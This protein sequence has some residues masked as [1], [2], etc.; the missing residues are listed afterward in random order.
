IDEL[1]RGHA[2]GCCMTSDVIEQ[3]GERDRVLSAGPKH[4]ARERNGVVESTGL[5]ADGAACA[6]LA[7]AF[8]KSAVH[9]ADRELRHELVL[10]RRVLPTVAE[11]LRG[12]ERG[13]AIRVEQP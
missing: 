3:D 7:K 6:R 1:V 13:R 2:S 12:A 4:V 9:A 11:Q 8:V 10:Y 5:R